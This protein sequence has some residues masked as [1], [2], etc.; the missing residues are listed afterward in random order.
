MKISLFPPHSAGV[1]FYIVD[2]VHRRA[3]PLSFFLEWIQSMRYHFQM[4][5]SDLPWLPAD[6]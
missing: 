4:L 5:F 6:F 3:L 2:Y 1:Y